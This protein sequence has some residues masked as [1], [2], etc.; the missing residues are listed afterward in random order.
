MDDFSDLGLE[1]GKKSKNSSVEEGNRILL[2]TLEEFSGAGGWFMDLRSLEFTAL[3]KMTYD[4]YGISEDSEVSYEKF[5]YE[6]V[7]LDDQPLVEKIRIRLIGGESP[8]FFEHKIIK[9]D[10]GEIRL[11]KSIAY[12]VEDQNKVLLGLR[13]ITMYAKKQPRKA[14]QKG[15]EK[16]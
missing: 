15:G 10:T 5:L 9:Q 11:L 14:S 13:G 3:G 8:V 6:Y 2:N 4:I 12:R 7:H 1:Y 16:R